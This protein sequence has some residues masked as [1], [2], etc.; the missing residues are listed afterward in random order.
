MAR[1]ISASALFASALVTG[2]L[3]TGAGA[4]PAY[5]GTASENPAQAW[6]AR[7][8]DPAFSPAQSSA[9]AVTGDPAQ[10]FLARFVPTSYTPAQPDPVVAVSDSHPDRDFIARLSTGDSSIEEATL[11][12]SVEQTAS[13]SAM[14]RT[15]G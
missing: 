14:L 11:A 9:S 7:I 15:G 2:A 13:R 12:P 10:A 1:T 4:V 8:E 5:A 3:F 6:I